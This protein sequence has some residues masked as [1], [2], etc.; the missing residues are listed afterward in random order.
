MKLMAELLQF[1]VPDIVHVGSQC[2]DLLGHLNNRANIKG[3]DFGANNCL[4]CLVGH[5]ADK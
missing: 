5:S 1:H 3:N 2:H 4:L